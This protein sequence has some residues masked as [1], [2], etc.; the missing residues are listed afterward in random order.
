M[1]EITY[2]KFLCSAAVFGL[3]SD[4][5]LQDN[6]IC[7]HGFRYRFCYYVIRATSIPIEWWRH[8]MET[9]SALLAFCAGNSSVTGEFLSQ[10]PVTWSFLFPMTWA[11]ID[12]WLNNREACDLRRHHGHYD[13]TVMGRKQGH[14]MPVYAPCCFRLHAHVSPM[15]I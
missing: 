4:L 3:N 6:F 1:Y 13:V 14:A 8:Q 15:L 5:K 2:I 12:V 11:W 9:F 7:Q 10:R